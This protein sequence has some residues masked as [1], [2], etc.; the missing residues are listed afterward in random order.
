M[1]NKGIIF[2]LTILFLVS[3][4]AAGAGYY[5][6]VKTPTVKPE[7]KEK[8]KVAYI[9]YLEDER[10]NDIPKNNVTI[11]ENGEATTE[12]LYKFLKFSCTNDL[13]GDFDETEWVFKPAV[14]KDSTCSLYFVKS[15]YSV[16]LT[17]VNGTASEN[18][19]E[20]VLREESGEFAI[21][22]HEG[23][24]YKDAVC[25]DDKEVNWDEKRNMLIVNAVTKDVMCKVNFTV[26]T[27]TAKFTVINGTGKTSESVEYG[28]SVSAIV[29]AKDGYEKPKVDCT[30]KQ[31]ATFADNK[32]TIETLT[33]NTEC[34]IT[35]TAVPV[36]KF[37][38]LLELPSQV[39]V[40]SGTISQDIESGKDGT[41]TLQVDEGYVPSIDCGDVTPSKVEPIDSYTTKYTF[42]TVKKNITCKV[43]ATADVSEEN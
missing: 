14:E 8:V 10:V 40:V 36:E 6:S 41:F 43:K 30:N 34:K 24:E 28:N 12:I 4:A 18:N 33:K 35:F 32:V 20:Y 15:K 11:D 7:P 29:E 19:P 5:Q 42:L 31:T 26:K 9:Y 16:T 21:T 17:V 23:Y 38:L 37:K 2:L 27:L 3:T 22:P 1:K 39:T 25:S 13:T